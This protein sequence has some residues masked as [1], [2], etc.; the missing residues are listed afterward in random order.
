LD[1]KRRETEYNRNRNQNP[2]RIPIIPKT[3]AQLKR[4]S[5]LNLDVKRRETEYNRNRNRKQNHSNEMDSTVPYNL[6]VL[7]G[8]VVIMS[9][10]PNI[11]RKKKKKK[12]ATPKKTKKR[13]SN[14]N[15]DRLIISGRMKINH[16]DFRTGKYKDWRQGDL[17]NNNGVDGTC[18][19][20]WKDDDDPNNIDIVGLEY[21]EFDFESRLKSKMLCN[22]CGNLID[23]HLRRCS[24]C[25]NR[26][27]NRDPKA[28]C[29]SLQLYGNSSTDTAIVNDLI[30]MK[31]YKNKFT[32]EHEKEARILIEDLYFNTTTEYPNQKHIVWND[33]KT[34]KLEQT[35][36]QGDIYLYS[37][38][39]K[40]PSLRA[41]VDVFNA[42]EINNNDSIQLQAT[43]PSEGLIKKVYPHNVSLLLLINKLDVISE[44]VKR[45]SA[46]ACV[47]V[48]AAAAATI[49]NNE[50][51]VFVLKE[52]RNSTIYTKTNLSTDV[53]HNNFEEKVI[54]I[55]ITEINS[56]QN[57]KLD[58]II[59]FIESHNIMEVLSSNC[60][61]P[62]DVNE[63]SIMFG[64]CSGQKRQE[65][66]SNR[67][68]EY[69][70]NDGILMTKLM[71]MI[72]EYIQLTELVLQHKFPIVYN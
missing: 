18:S 70:T 26:C 20:T 68:G 69:C 52:G 28:N 64:V 39:G 53:G 41:S 63:N 65:G 62:G 8:G 60:Q 48:A 47:V 55:K 5:R 57:V 43:P 45:I 4:K 34:E 14:N 51:G 7:V 67:C 19:I 29:L 1:V 24:A 25:D 44:Q 38:D 30:T 12:E 56:E 46:E 31:K 58:E 21:I 50:D 66:I 10:M 72:N 2:N 17:V 61:G 3:Q 36:T 15:R 37:S 33:N 13:S 49:N 9:S 16:P 22:K 40:T 32:A 6:K 23:I 27:K 59:S 71:K 54:P 42:N 11:Q 35:I